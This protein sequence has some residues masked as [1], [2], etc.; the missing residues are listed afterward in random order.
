MPS[1]W[2]EGL[3]GALIAGDRETQLC[4]VSELRE[5]PVEP[6]RHQEAHRAAG[7]GTWLSQSHTMCSCP[8][9]HPATEPVLCF[10]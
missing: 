4:K 2:D 3:R 10:F 6:R 5:W 9:P 8:P 7:T 1:P